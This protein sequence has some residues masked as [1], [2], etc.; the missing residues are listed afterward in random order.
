MKKTKAKEVSEI[1]LVIGLVIGIIIAIIGSLIS[2]RKGVEHRK[3][4]AEAEIESAEKE[5]QRLVSEAE[6][7]AERK[8]A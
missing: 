3:R 6:K 2:F 7:V 4:V 5:S 8:K 1:E